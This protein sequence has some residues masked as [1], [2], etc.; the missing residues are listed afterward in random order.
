MPLT[1]V[2]NQQRLAVTLFGV[3]DGTNS[4]DVVV[5][6]GVLLGDVNGSR[7]VDGND[8]SAVQS[9]TRQALNGTNFQYD[10]NVTGRVD[11]NDASVTQ[12]Q[13]RSAL[14]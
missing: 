9:H 10:V 4:N 3:N 8:V 11:G 1:S 13:T 7:R 5:P 14:P 6:V 12:S 2:T